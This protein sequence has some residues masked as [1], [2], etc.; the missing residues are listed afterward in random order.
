LAEPT[1]LA[2]EPNDEVVPPVV[3]WTPP[4]PSGASTLV[5]VV[6]TVDSSSAGRWPSLSRSVACQPRR[7]V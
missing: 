2:F 4:A 5:V 6:S 3:Q 7:T 1:L